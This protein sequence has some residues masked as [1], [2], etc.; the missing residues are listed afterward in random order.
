MKKHLNLITEALV[1]CFCRIIVSFL[2]LSF[3]I[4]VEAILIFSPVVWYYHLLNFILIAF[5][6]Y[7]YLKST[8]LFHRVRH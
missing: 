5:F 7:S 4:L 2:W 3:F 8:K 1:Y 6:F